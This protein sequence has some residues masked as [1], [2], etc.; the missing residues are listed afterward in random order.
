MNGALAAED[1]AVS[2][3]DFGDAQLERDAVVGHLAEEAYIAAEVLCEVLG[4]AIQESGE[5]SVEDLLDDLR[6]D[7]VLVDGK[8]RGALVSH[9]ACHDGGITGEGRHV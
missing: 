6:T 1:G 2:G 3:K 5:G 9:D 7:D 4:I 8:A